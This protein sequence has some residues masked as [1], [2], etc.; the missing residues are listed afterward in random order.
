MSEPYAYFPYDK[1]NNVP[2]TLFE[3]FNKKMQG[4]NIQNFRTVA[5]LKIKNIYFYPGLKKL[6]NR[7]FDS[8][9]DFIS[10]IENYPLNRNNNYQIN[11]FLKNIKSN[12]PDPNY[13]KEQKYF[14]KENWENNKHILLENK[15]SNC[16]NLFQNTNK[17]FFYIGLETNLSFDEV[18]QYV[19][20][21]FRL[22]YTT[23]YRRE[24]KIENK[25]AIQQKISRNENI[26]SIIST[27]I[28]YSCSA[29]F[30]QEEIIKAIN[31][32][33]TDNENRQAIKKSYLH[34]LSQKK[35]VMECMNSIYYKFGRQE[36]KRRPILPNKKLQEKENKQRFQTINAITV[37]TETSKST[38]INCGSKNETIYD[39][40]FYTPFK[41]TVTSGCINCLLETANTLREVKMHH[42]SSG[43][44]SSQLMVN[45]QHNKQTITKCHICG[46]LANPSFEFI[47]VRQSDSVILCNSCTKE[48]LKKM[49]K[50]RSDHN[51][52]NEKNTELHI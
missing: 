43:Q 36:K 15:D 46:N 52:P 13:L 47:T 8:L 25:E 51:I 20:T 37:D 10:L 9:Y 21:L 34:M 29:L 26:N 23:L 31:K 45:C 24:K 14:I 48:L 7:Y 1:K 40:D 11:L 12:L 49:T 35:L 44:I 33:I 42:Y 30:E 39:V 41:H 18:I 32:R 19:N 3:Y 6:T 17:L 28:C 38:C 22:D 27:I 16:F 5:D 50:E 2:I 4:D